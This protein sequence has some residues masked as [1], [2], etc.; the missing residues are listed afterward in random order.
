VT[1][2]RVEVEERRTWI[3][4]VDSEDQRDAEDTATEL[5]DG[6]E[7]DNYE[8]EAHGFRVSN[9]TT[10]KKTAEVWVGGEEG[11]FISYADYKR[12]QHSV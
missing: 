10:I 4:Y 1:L 12:G 11:Q 9:K 7:A 6:F 3:V 2:Y 5:V 8:V